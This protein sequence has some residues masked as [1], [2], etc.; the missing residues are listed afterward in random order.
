MKQVRAYFTKIPPESSIQCR[1][2]KQD[3]TLLLILLILDLRLV[4]ETCSILPRPWCSSGVGC[5]S[6]SSAYTKQINKQ[7]NNHHLLICF[8]TF[9]EKQNPLLFRERVE[10]KTLLCER[11]INWL[12]HAYASPGVQREPATQAH[13]LD[14]ELNPLPFGVWVDALTTEIPANH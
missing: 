7:T 13:A 5:G 12:P 11:H 8:S 4:E 14:R 9:S 10:E 6:S 3:P 2:S 1:S